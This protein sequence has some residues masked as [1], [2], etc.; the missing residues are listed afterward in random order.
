MNLRIRHIIRIVLLIL[1]QVLVLKQVNLGS[2]NFNYIFLFIYPVGIMMLPINTPKIGVLL[3]AFV[4]GLTVDVFYDSPGLH[5][6]ALVFMAFIRSFVLRG[7]SPDTGYSKNATPLAHTF[8]LIWFLQYSAI[9]LFAFLIVYFG[10]EAFTFVYIWSILAKTFFS[11]LAS[12][13]I[14]ILHQILFSPKV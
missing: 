10:L 7:L 13:A 2:E 11:F 4:V 3:I 8:G 5:G 12:F 6:A 9:M 14:I 1:I